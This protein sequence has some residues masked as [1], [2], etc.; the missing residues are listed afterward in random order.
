MFT[1]TQL[2]G[3]AVPAGKI[4]GYSRS[5]IGPDVGIHTHDQVTVHIIVDSELIA[6]VT[7]QGTQLTDTWTHGLPADITALLPRPVLPWSPDKCGDEFHGVTD[8]ELWRA[9]MAN[10]DDNRLALRQLTE[11]R[12]RGL[13]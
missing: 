9:M 3:M 11:M 10:E 13:L 1:H 2:L 6:R 4:G 12:A 8:R 7:H 5:P